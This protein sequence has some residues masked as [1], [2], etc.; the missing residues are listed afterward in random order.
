MKIVAFGDSITLGVRADGS[1][2]EGE[3]W[4]AV[5]ERRL[6]ASGGGRV[7]IVNAGIGGNTTAGGLKR[8]DADVLANRPDI[9]TILFGVN[10]AAMLSF[11]D[12]K[13]IRSPRVALAQ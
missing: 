4:R 6:N 12:F 9:V 8:M 11:P 7:E 5:L 2:K 3:T 13:P 10:D 1:L